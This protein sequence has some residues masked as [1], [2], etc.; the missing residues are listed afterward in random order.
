VILFFY[1]II[2]EP[3]TYLG[4]DS[5]FRNLTGSGSVLILFRGG[6]LK[7]DKCIVIY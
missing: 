2:Y 6:V 5:H 7:D 3:K 4:K 1:N